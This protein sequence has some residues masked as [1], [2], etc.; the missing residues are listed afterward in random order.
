MFNAIKTKNRQKGVDMKIALPIKDTLNIY[1][2]NP[3]TA[4]KFAIYIIENINNTIHFSLHAIV[5]NPLSDLKCHQFTE[6]EKTCSCDA[7]EQ[8]SLMH[9]C[10]HYSLL[11]SIG[12]CTYLLAN[13]YCINTR[14]S[15]KKAGIKIFQVPPIISKIDIVIKNFIIGASLANKIKNIHHAS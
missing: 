14:N 8:K 10:E 6:E 7:E 5:D 9:K 2:D 1:K 4:P 13:K 12:D 11:E 15:M 3:H